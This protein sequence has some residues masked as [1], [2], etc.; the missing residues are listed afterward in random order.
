MIRGHFVLAW[1]LVLSGC[2]EEPKRRRGAP[3]VDVTVPPE[4]G[5]INRRMAILGCEHATIDDPACADQPP[6]PRGC[7]GWDPSPP[8]LDRDAVLDATCTRIYVELRAFERAS[9]A[10]LKHAW[11]S[12]ACRERLGAVY[13]ALS[14]THRSDWATQWMRADGAEPW[15]LPPDLDAPGS[16]RLTEAVSAW[17][18]GAP[19]RDP[20]A[21]R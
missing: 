21:D 5:A 3:P 16:Q 7:A 10:V 1:A 8:A 14:D 19:C 9:L 17:C 20:K 13:D 11:R 12:T 4:C 2:P 15:K 6:T 18:S